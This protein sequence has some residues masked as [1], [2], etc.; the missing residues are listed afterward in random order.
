M[1]VLVPRY[2]D[3]TSGFT[4]VVRLGNRIG[5]GAPKFQIELIQDE[6]PVAVKTEKVKSD[7]KAKEEIKSEDT[8]IE[9][10]NTEEG[11]NE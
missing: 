7:K 2:S 11:K 10:A 8:N 3:R 4:R 6:K 5:D 1:E 9:P